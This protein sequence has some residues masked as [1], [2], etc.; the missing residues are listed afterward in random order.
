MEDFSAY[1][2]HSHIHIHTYLYIYVHTHTHTHTH[3]H[4]MLS[5]G[6]PDTEQDSGVYVCTVYN[7]N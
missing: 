5:P 1:N 7:K 3:S 4:R 6:D 2:T